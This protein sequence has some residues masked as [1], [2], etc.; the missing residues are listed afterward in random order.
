MAI[1]FWSSVYVSFGCCCAY[2]FHYIF[3]FI[4][5]AN[6]APCASDSVSSVTYKPTCTYTNLLWRSLLGSSLI[7][8]FAFV[9]FFFLVRIIRTCKELI[10]CRCLVCAVFFLFQTQSQPFLHSV[11]AGSGCALLL[12]FFLFIRWFCLRFD[13]HKLFAHFIKRILFIDIW[14]L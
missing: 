4:L 12:L 5:N 3:D 7:F 8:C 10:V 6:D 9:F 1:P 14:H 13:W 2:L 11:A